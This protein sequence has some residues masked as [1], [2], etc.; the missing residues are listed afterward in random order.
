MV[1]PQFADTDGPSFAVSPEGDLVYKRSSAENHGYYFR[2]V[3]GW[4]A[5]MKRA[6][7]E[8]NP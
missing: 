6:V 4:I 2:V 7:N 3:P 5:E 1:D 8:A